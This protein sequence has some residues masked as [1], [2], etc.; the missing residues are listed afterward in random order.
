MHMI[1]MQETKIFPQVQFNKTYPLNKQYT[2][3]IHTSKLDYR[4]AKNWASQ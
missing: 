2:F 4:T 1:H 3:Q